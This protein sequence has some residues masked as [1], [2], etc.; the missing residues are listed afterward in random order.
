[1]REYGGEW[2]E[3]RPNYQC[4]DTVLY[5]SSR[6]NIGGKHLTNQLKEV[7]SYRQLMVM[8]ETFVINQVKEDLCFVSTDFTSDIQTAQ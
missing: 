5:F 4:R 8:D 7:I 2:L 3:M 6:I 1:L